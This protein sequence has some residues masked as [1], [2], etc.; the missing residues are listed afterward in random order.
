MSDGLALNPE[1]LSQVSESLSKQSSEGSLS[2]NSP[3]ESNLIGQEFESDLEIESSGF[4]ENENAPTDKEESEEAESTEE[5]EESEDETDASEAGQPKTIKYKANGEELEASIEDAQKALAL[6]TA[7]RQAL[8]N[9]GEMKKKVRDLETAKQE[10]SKYQESW[11]K[12]EDLRDDPD[13]LMEILFNKPIKELRKQI[14][15]EYLAYEDAS[16]E[17]RSVLDHK[18]ELEEMKRDYKRQQAEAEK[19]KQDLDSR[20][21]RAEKTELKNGIETEFGKYEFGDIEPDVAGGLREML[22]DASISTLKRYNQKYG[23]I[24]Q[25]MI[26]TAIQQNYEKLMAGRTKAIAK[27]EQQNKAVHQQDAK[28]KAQEVATQNYKGKN[29]VTQDMLKQDPMSLFNNFFRKR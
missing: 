17:M 3:E 18:R 23:T 25:K 24:N 20:N 2:I 5:N 10:L 28:R 13:K 12:L 11:Q 22:W 7:A 1:Q 4:W 29:K 8:T 9:Q 15:E 26:K 27:V 19:H 21:Y 16:P 14:A 6:Q